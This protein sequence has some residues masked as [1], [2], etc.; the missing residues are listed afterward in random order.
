VLCVLSIVL[1]MTIEGRNQ[2]MANRVMHTVDVDYF[3][4]GFV[5]FSIKTETLMR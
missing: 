4:T 3:R 5:N 2:R 1:S